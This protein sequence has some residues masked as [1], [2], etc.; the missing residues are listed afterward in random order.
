MACMCTGVSIWSVLVRTG[1]AGET[2]TTASDRTS[3]ATRASC[4]PRDRVEPLERGTSS[5]IQGRLNRR[6]DPGSSDTPTH[7]G[8]IR[9]RCVLG[10]ANTLLFSTSRW[11]K[12]D[13]LARSSKRINAEQIQ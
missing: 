13:H 9:C 3:S 12:Q 11:K 7:G 4:S 8:Y 6:R 2:R 1:S 5:D 10:V